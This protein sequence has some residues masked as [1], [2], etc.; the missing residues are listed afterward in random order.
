VAASTALGPLAPLVS[1]ATEPLALDAIRPLIG[2]ATR[3]GRDDLIVARRTGE[4]AI[5]IVV[6]RASTMGTSFVRVSFTDILPPLSFAGTRFS[7][8]DATG[9]GRVDLFA[10]VNRGADADGS[11][12]GTDVVRLLSTGTTFSMEPWFSSPTMS[13]GTAFPY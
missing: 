2:D 12:L 7:A 13:W 8:A 9:D 1:W 10:L 11:L 6:Y 5:S 3:D 4:D